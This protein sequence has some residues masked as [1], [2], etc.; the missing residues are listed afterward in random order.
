MS[1]C[2]GEKKRTNAALLP[3]IARWSWDS[4]KGSSGSQ[5]HCRSLYRHC[6]HQHCRVPNLGRHFQANCGYQWTWWWYQWR[7][8]RLDGFD[9]C[10][11]ILCEFEC[12]RR[13]KKKVDCNNVDLSYEKFEC[14]ILKWNEFLD[15]FCGVQIRNHTLERSVTLL[16]SIRSIN[17]SFVFAKNTWI[18][19][20]YG[21]RNHIEIHAKKDIVPWFRR[22]KARPTYTGTL[23]PSP[24]WSTRTSLRRS[25]HSTKCSPLVTITVDYPFTPSFSPLVVGMRLHCGKFLI[26][27]RGSVSRTRGK[28]WRPP[29]VIV[30]RS[31]RKWWSESWDW[32]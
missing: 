5:G 25:S 12:K 21:H 28:Q 18:V 24:N 20:S 11:G 31:G 14:R 30:S 8:R 19:A 9:G 22:P 4:T 27:S 6:S 7:R 32:G 16:P 10:K 23:L 2:L 1:V 17:A 13:R 15:S 26:S 3:F 29:V